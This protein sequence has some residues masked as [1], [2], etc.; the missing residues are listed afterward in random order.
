MEERE[1]RYSFILSRT[2]R[3]YLFIFISFHVAGPQ[4]FPDDPHVRRRGVL[5]H[6]QHRELLRLPPGKVFNKSRTFMISDLSGY[7]PPSAYSCTKT[8][9][10]AHVFG[11]PMKPCRSSRL[12]LVTHPLAK[13]KVT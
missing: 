1:R 7:L 13:H 10:A 12:S 3:E 11:G 9:A 5:R 2:P 6:A 4:R 8:C